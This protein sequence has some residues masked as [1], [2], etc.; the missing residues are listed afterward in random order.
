MDSDTDIYISAN[1][2][3]MSVWQDTDAVISK[4]TYRQCVFQS[5]VHLT[6][7][8]NNNVEAA[9]PSMSATKNIHMYISLLF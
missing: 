2:L 9:R 6:L 1:P 3:D 7:P 4:A 8:L 5:Y